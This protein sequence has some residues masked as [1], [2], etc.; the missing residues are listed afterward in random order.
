[1]GPVISAL[2]SMLRVDD[3]DVRLAATMIRAHH[4]AINDSQAGMDV[5]AVPWSRMAHAATATVPSN[6]AVMERILDEAPVRR[7]RELGIEYGMLDEIVAF[8]NDP[9]SLYGQNGRECDVCDRIS[10]D[11]AVDWDGPIGA[12]HFFDEF[13]D[14]TMPGGWVW[15]DPNGRNTGLGRNRR[16]SAQ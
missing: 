7:A 5:T 12:A 9:G 11:L 2:N 3:R 10:E 15:G 16:M 14:G 6:W 8:Q 1:M 4:D 13:A